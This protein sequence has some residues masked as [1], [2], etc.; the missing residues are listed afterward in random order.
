VLRRVYEQGHVPRVGVR[1]EGLDVRLAL[2]AAEELVMTGQPNPVPSGDLT[3]LVPQLGRDLELVRRDRF[4]VVV[5]GR[6]HHDDVVQIDGRPVPHGDPEV[7]QDALVRLRHVGRV[8]AQV[9]VGGVEGV[10]DPLQAVVLD[11]L[12][13]LRRP[14]VVAVHLPQPEVECVDGVEPDGL[15]LFE[16]RRHRAV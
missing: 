1:V 12:L 16:K 3:D 15:D 5:Q 6:R 9:V 13:V 11:H 2:D 10:D 4:H 7:L 14:A 8:V